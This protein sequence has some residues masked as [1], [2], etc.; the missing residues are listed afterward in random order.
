MGAR[1][2]GQRV[3]FSFMLVLG[4]IALQTDLGATIPSFCQNWSSNHDCSCNTQ[5]DWAWTGSCDFSEEENPL[6]LQH[7]Y[8]IGAFDNCIDSCE[9]EAY[10]QWLVEEYCS[11]FF[12]DEPE[13]YEECWVPYAG[14]NSCNMGEQSDFTCTCDAYVWCM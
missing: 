8:C 9:S 10:V 3:A 7:D 1:T 6:E 5:A 2:T 12:P 11:P 4:F 13:C 14:A